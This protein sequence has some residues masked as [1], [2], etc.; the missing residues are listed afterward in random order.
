MFGAARLLAF[1][2]QRFP[3]AW[4]EGVMARRT[5]QRVGGSTL[6]QPARGF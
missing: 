4:A 3:L 1:L 5:I 6:G 2:Q